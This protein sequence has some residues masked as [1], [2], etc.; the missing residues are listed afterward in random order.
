MCQP[1]GAKW[2]EIRRFDPWREA[3]IPAAQ[4]GGRH[5]A[6]SATGVS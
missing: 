5:R 1:F 2:L 4:S 6:V 3:G